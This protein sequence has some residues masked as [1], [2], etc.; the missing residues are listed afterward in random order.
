MNFISQN[1]DV[2]LKSRTPAHSLPL[3]SAAAAAAAIAAAAA[4]AAYGAGCGDRRQ[5]G[6]P[7]LPGA[8]GPAP[9]LLRSRSMELPD[10]GSP[11]SASPYKRRSEWQQQHQHLKHRHEGRSS[12]SMAGSG[13]AKVHR[14]N[15]SPT[16]QQLGQ[17]ERQQEQGMPKP[18]A[19]GGYGTSIIADASFSGAELAAGH[20]GGG[21]RRLTSNQSEATAGGRRGTGD[22]DGGGLAP[23]VHDELDWL[24]KQPSSAEAREFDMLFGGAGS[25]PGTALHIPGSSGGQHGARGLLLSPSAGLLYSPRSRAGIFSPHYCLH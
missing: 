8:G 14:S 22:S 20:N 6:S 12:A 18:A 4:A 21:L 17:K 15:S 10:A 13:L 1:L 9:R 3:G 16:L 25:D 23:M 24:L 11:R 2:L 7:V 5:P 19:A